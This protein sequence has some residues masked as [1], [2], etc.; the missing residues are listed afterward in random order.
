MGTTLVTEK[1]NN[2]TSIAITKA[3]IDEYPPKHGMS[4]TLRMRF[5]PCIQGE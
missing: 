5:Y 1:K 2:N 4:A 3:I